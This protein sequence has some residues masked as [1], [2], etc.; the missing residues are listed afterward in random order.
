MKYAILTADEPFIS[1]AEL[2]SLLNNENNIYYFSGIAVFS[3]DYKNIARRSSN[4]KA[5]GEVLAISNDPKDINEVIRG[6]CFTIKPNVIL[7]SDKDR[8]NAL[9]ST[10]T[11]GVIFSKKCETLDLIFTDGIII[12]GLRE[13]ER[14]SKSLL[15]HAKKPYSQSGT[16]DAYTSRLMVNLANPKK[17][18]FD[19]FVGVGSILIESAWI[20]YTCLGADID[21]NMLEKTKYNL[22]YFGYTCDLLQSNIATNCIKKTDAIVTDPPYGKSVNAKTIKIEELYEKLFS[23][24]SEILSKNGRLV[25]ATDAKY[26]WRDKIKEYNLSIIGIHFIY[27]HK[28]LSRAIYVVQKR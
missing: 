9:Y 10:A 3:G 6:K 25:F 14:D 12:A 17:T 23:I 16:M 26:D 5:I 22:K 24:S 19:P 18:V 2:K 15:L 13:E 8:F 21:I 4:I 1:L 20:G 7:R 27:L 28:S 11:K